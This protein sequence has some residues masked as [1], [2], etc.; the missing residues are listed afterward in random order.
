MK[1]LLSLL[2]FLACSVFQLSA[3]DFLTPYSYG[4]YGGMFPGY[5]ET[6]FHTFLTTDNEDAHRN[7]SPAFF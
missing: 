2:G 3:Q 5:D 1:K 4:V 7:L 6:L